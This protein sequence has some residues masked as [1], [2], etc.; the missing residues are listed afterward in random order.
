MGGGGSAMASAAAPVPSASDDVVYP[1]APRCAAPAVPTPRLAHSSGG[2]A[3]PTSRGTDAITSEAL[4]LAPSVAT[5][6]LSLRS[7]IDVSPAARH[8]AAAGSP[9][10]R[11]PAADDVPK[12]CHLRRLPFARRVAPV[13]PLGSPRRRGAS[14][15]AAAAAEAEGVTR[16]EQVRVECGERGALLDEAIRRASVQWEASAARCSALR[17][18]AARLAAELARARPPAGAPD[19]GDEG[20]RGASA[21]LLAE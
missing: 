5:G 8:A 10:R 1:T 7:S 11:S 14:P 2:P 21:Y 3:T 13:S 19:S 9:P 17:D 6:T 15:R 16:A 12:L 4:S 18:E 20:G